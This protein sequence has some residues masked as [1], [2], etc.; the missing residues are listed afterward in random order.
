V[1]WCKE[2]Q[3]GEIAATAIPRWRRRNKFVV[4]RALD[5]KRMRMALVVERR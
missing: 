5:H 2:V 3:E 1:E 4:G